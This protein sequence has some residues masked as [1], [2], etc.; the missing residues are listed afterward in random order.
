MVRLND[1]RSLYGIISTIMI[2]TGTFI[3]DNPTT[4]YMKKNKARIFGTLTLLIGY[5]LFGYLI[6]YE[7]FGSY[8]ILAYL[9]MLVISRTIKGR[10]HQKLLDAL[11]WISI[12]YIIINTRKLTGKLQVAA[13]IASLTAYAS[14][15]YN[16]EPG[17]YLFNS[18][19]I[20]LFGLNAMN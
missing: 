12:A 14:K 11:S 5:C 2:I 10:K 18:S 20:S 7:T 16:T 1:I 9:P 19:L 3:R 13:Y 8:Q 4:S 6:G 15:Y 17:H